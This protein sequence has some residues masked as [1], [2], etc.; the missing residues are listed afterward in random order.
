AE[1]QQVL[2][3]DFSIE[4]SPLRNAP[5]TVA[6]V[7]NTA[8]DRKYTVEQAAFPVHALRVDKYFPTVGR[9]DGA[10]GDRNLICSC[11]PIEEFAN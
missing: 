11:P 6:A 4:E 1:M 3:G 8:W 7:V 9:I 5:H 2:A 10:G